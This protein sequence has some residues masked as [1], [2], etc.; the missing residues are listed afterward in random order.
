M[1][2]PYDAAS[3]FTTIMNNTLDRSVPYKDFIEINQDMLRQVNL[4]IKKKSTDDGD[5]SSSKSDS[6]SEDE[7]SPPKKKQK[8]SFKSVLKTHGE[9]SD[10]ENQDIIDLNDTD[11][12][13]EV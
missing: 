3:A 9:E 12:E 10:D 1:E 5:E 6:S 4:T 7:A 2:K 8:S 11:D 13:E